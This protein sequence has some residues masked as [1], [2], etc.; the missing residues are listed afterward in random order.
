MINRLIEKVNNLSLKHQLFG[1]ALIILITDL[2]ITFD[3]PIL[4]QAFGFLTF[5]LIPGF[6]IVA[7][8]RLEKLGFTEKFVLSVGLSVA[9][10]MFVGLII[11][12]V[13]YAI[14]Y[15]TPLSTY[16]LMI[17]FSTI[18]FLM[19]FL[20]MYQAYKRNDNKNFIIP[21]LDFKTE[22]EKIL[23]IIPL[24]FPLLSVF[25]TY[26]MNTRDNNS[27]L[28][29]LYFLIPIYVAL[30][31]F[32]RDRVS[33]KVY[34]IAII[35]I[36]VSLL[37]MQSLRS[38]YLLGTDIHE[39]HY[40]SQTISSLMHWDMEYATTY[41]Y[42]PVY[43]AC[44]SVTI[45]PAEYFSLANIDVYKI[46]KIF[47]PLIYAIVPLI[48]YLISKRY[49]GG[50]YAFL[51]SF[52]YMSQ[53]YFILAGLY[54]I[55]TGLAVFFVGLAIFV[56]FNENIQNIK[57]KILFIIFLISVIF[58]HYSTSYTL[59][60]VMFVSLII[61]FLM[62]IKFKQTTAL[63]ITVVI[64]FFSV[65]F[66]WYGQLTETPF[67]SG[68]DM[69]KNTL[70]KLNDFFV[71]ESR[72]TVQLDV[73][74]AKHLTMEAPY[75]ISY[76]VHMLTFFL[77]GIGT[78][79]VAYNL[80]K[81]DRKF[82]ADYTI[83]SFALLSVVFIVLI[84]PFGGYDYQRPYSVALLLLSPMFFI[85]GF[86]L[87]KFLNK[88]ISFCIIFSILIL[89]FICASYLIFQIFGIP[90]SVTLN[91]EGEYYNYFWFYDEEIVSSMWLKDNKEKNIAIYGDYLCGV[92]N[93]DKAGI[94]CHYN[95][96][97]NN[98]TITKAYVY[99]RYQNVKEKKVRIDTGYESEAM[100]NINEYTPLFINKNKIYNNGGSEI[101]Q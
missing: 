15:K 2:F 45:L 92:K 43:N 67:T 90:Y 8:M 82:P 30:V 44:L 48:V 18:M 3:I 29:F 78:I 88:K 32:L 5:T 59:F 35:M 36:A 65:I 68:V 89:Q 95:F 57:K 26:L 12:E 41:Y 74:T 77:I 42:S 61:V 94:G 6:L 49:V 100:K 1:I 38:D 79:I 53:M 52:F 87:L 39:E 91:S 10:L 70:E 33:N 50:F 62:K 47:Y 31:A 55:R 7:I 17:S 9:F 21:T 14:G 25:G 22:T 28:L 72:N 97:K 98:E 56:F 96:F 83:L 84:I 85:A 86:E 40:I 80:L 16:S 101:Y 60:I 24:I 69:V 99:L 4:R 75:K 63:T 11:N 51:V 64:L 66:F 93:V 20:I 19:I 37:L 13:Y 34:V 54:P 73:L 81:G 23:F 27:V 46:F 58:S 71:E 76:I